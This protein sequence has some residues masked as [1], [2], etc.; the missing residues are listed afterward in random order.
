MAAVTE[1]KRLNRNGK[2][3]LQT[4]NKIIGYFRVSIFLY[5]TLGCSNEFKD[6]EKVISG[7]Y[8]AVFSDKDFEK[9]YSH[10]SAVPL[11]D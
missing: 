6:P 8:K 10:C 7:Y 2:E 11:I 1:R 4:Q 5:L 9:S 3:I